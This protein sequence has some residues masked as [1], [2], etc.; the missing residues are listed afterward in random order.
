MRLSAFAAR[1]GPPASAHR[2]WMTWQT[3]VQLPLA[4]ARSCSPSLRTPN[5][6]S[7]AARLV[8]LFTISLIVLGYK[9]Q[10]GYGLL[11]LSLLHVPGGYS[12]TR[13]GSQSRSP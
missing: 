8:P 9:P 7:L 12:G 3:D 4:V 6:L 1:C 10:A 2:V 11:P 13:S 5:A